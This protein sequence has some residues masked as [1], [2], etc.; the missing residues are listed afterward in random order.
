MKQTARSYAFPGEIE[1]EVLAAGSGQVPYMRTAE[2]SALVKSLEQR[3]LTMIGCRGG[4][5]IPLTGSGTG[6]MDAVVTGFVKSLPGSA[7]VVDGGSFGHRWAE[8]CRYYD[9]PVTTFPVP[10]GRDIDYSAL[11]QA[12]D[13]ERPDVLLMQHHETSSGQLFDIPRVGAMCH[14][15]GVKFVVD[16]VSS[17]LSE[18][19]DMDACGI[20]VA[21]TSSQKGLNIY[22]GLSFIFLSS[23]LAGHQFAH[24][25]YYF[26]LE[27]NLRNLTRGQTPWSPATM[28]F[29]M[30]Q[31]RLDRLDATGG[32]QGNIERVAARAER[33][34]MRLAEFG[35]DM[36]VE[37]KANCITGFHLPELPA[38]TFARDMIEQG[39]YIMPG[40][41]PTYF[42]VSHLGADS[43][44]DV[45]NLANAIIACLL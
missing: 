37:V 40:G 9:V 26:D 42:R 20:D 41:N 23:S 15:R 28:L 5:M 16:V 1:P 31:E 38:K 34:R 22:P 7:L 12:L 21:V 30:L 6:A 13:S 45:D 8:L 33:F 19:L 25:S 39:Y 27:E 29:L 32:V 24:G 36:P 4:R 10:F 14:A 17:F 3:L 2:F 44:E 11:E 43:Q 35:I 18:P